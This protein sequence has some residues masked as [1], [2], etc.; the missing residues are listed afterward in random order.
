[1]VRSTLLVA[2]LLLFFAMGS[3]RAGI[4]VAYSNVYQDTEAGETVVD[5]GEVPRWI[6]GKSIIFN[7]L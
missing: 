3:V 2:V 6:N 4:E 1:M 7:P 5:V